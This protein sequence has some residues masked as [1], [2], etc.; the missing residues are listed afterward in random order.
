MLVDMT[1]LI[2]FILTAPFT[3]SNSRVSFVKSYSF[4]QKIIN[5]ACLVKICK[6]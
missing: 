6:E 1:T 3:Y 2:L 5:W 4:L